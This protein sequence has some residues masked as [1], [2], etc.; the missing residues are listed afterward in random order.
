M[1]DHFVSLI[2]TYVAVWVP[3]LAA[4]LADY[5]IE[6]PVEPATVVATALG[7]SA[8]YTLARLLESQ[9]PWL[10]VLLGSTKQPSY[11]VKPRAW[12]MENR[13]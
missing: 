10:G 9:V 3:T 1:S 6:L 4:V 13:M 2:R 7:V 8:Y 11:A 12:H 5:G